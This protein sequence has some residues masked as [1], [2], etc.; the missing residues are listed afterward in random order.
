MDS[1]GIGILGFV[2]LGIFLLVFVGAGIYALTLYAREKKKGAETQTWP[3]VSGRVVEAYVAEDVQVDSEGDRN[4]VFAPRVVY[5]YEVNGQTYRGDRLR[6][7]IE[8]F[9]GSRRR[10]EQELARYP[11]G[12]AVTVYYNPANPAEAVLQRGAGSKAALVI[13]ITFLVI[14]G[15]TACLVAVA[16][17]AT[18][19]TQ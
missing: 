14:A 6:I 5:E 3:A 17:L 7:G 12:S 10:V 19:L 11:V 9:S 2:C 15:M 16:A 13:G 8:S 18:L 1:S 4:R